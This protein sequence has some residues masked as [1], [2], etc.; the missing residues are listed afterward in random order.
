MQASRRSNQGV[1]QLDPMTLS[2]LPQKHPGSLAD[3]GING[4]RL[5]CGEDRLKNFVLGL[6]SP[7]PK[8]CNGHR[9]AEDSRGSP[10][11]GVPLRQNAGVTSARDFN[12]NI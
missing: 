3:F 11:Q 10:A 2:V 1:A 5:N 9:G 7:M 4:D 8:L 6:A 12:Q